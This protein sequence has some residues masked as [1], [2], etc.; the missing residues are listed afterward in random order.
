[1]VAILKALVPQIALKMTFAVIFHQLGVILFA[2]CVC[3]GHQDFTASKSLIKQGDVN[4]QG[5]FPIT[6]RE[7]ER[8][9]GLY[10]EGVIWAMAMKFAIDSINNSTRLQNVTLGYKIDNTCHHIPTSMHNAIEIVAKY[11]PNSVCYPQDLYCKD[12]SKG[13]EKISAV[14]GPALSWIAIPI[15]SLL[16][17]YEIPQI[18]YAS[19][20]RILS[21]KTRYNSFLRTVPS[22]EYQAKAMAEFVHKFGWN[23]VFLIASDD[24]YGKMGAAKF[25][26]TAKSLNVCIANDEYIPF[27]SDMLDDYVRNTLNT[28]KSSSRAKVVIVFTYAD[29]GERLLK[30]ASKM[31][32]TD[33]TWIA[34]D[35]WSSVTEFK[36]AKSLLEGIITFSIRSKK[37]DAFVDYINNLQIKDAKNIP[38]FLKY[39]EN[40]LN[41]VYGNVTQGAKRRCLPNETL[42]ANHTFSDEGIANVID[43][44][45]ATA[46]ALATILGCEK[47]KVCKNK[48]TDIKPLELLQIIKNSSFLG[49][50]NTKVEFNQNGDRASSGYTIRNVQIQNDKLVYVDV[51]HWSEVQRKT[52]FE[53]NASLIKWNKGIKPQ[54]N[55]FR[56]CQP[57]ER[58]VGQTECCWN[59]QRCEKGT[60]SSIQGALTCTKCNET[61]YTNSQRTICLARKVVYLSLHDPAGV[62]I[63][64]ISTL[65]IV[66]TSVIS[67]IFIRHRDTPIIATSTSFH[68]VMFF[69]ILYISFFFAMSFAL[70]KPS[71][72]MCIAIESIFELTMMLFSSFLLSKTRIVNKAARSALKQVKAMRQEW[73]HVT[74]VVVLMVLQLILV[75]ARQFVSP[76]HIHYVNQDKTRLLGCEQVFTSLRVLAI[77]VPSCILIIS[78]F[79][80]FRE[81]DIPDNFNEAKFISFTTILLCIIFISFI[82]TYKYVSGI[83]RILVLTFTTFVAAFSAMGCICIPKL[84]IIYMHPERNVN[85]QQSSIDSTASE[86][87]IPSARNSVSDGQSIDLN[88]NMKST[89][90]PDELN[91]LGVNTTYLTSFLNYGAEPGD[92]S[93]EHETVNQSKYPANH[94]KRKDSTD[95]AK[96]Q[97]QK[98]SRKK[99]TGRKSEPTNQNPEGKEVTNEVQEKQPTNGRKKSRNHVT[100]ELSTLPEMVEDSKNPDVEE[101][102]TNLGCAG[103][104]LET[105]YNTLDI[106]GT[107]R[108]FTVI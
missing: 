88:S 105:E 46:N 54:S 99:S 19:T 4:L 62:S 101:Q 64:I 25:K 75:I 20:S 91:F 5:L 37:V 48:N 52:F 108:A 89:A 26:N 78:T 24:D 79:I 21:D 85:S 40:V 83:S 16:G 10:N 87:P 15:A 56:L 33:R 74:V 93:I 9:Q 65:G 97:R 39:M 72:S 94:V 57:G 47:G 27:T 41:C 45:N 36:L 86:Q 61:H 34:S 96:G 28:L 50:D 67:G 43:A 30:E 106:R 49:V 11:R 14:I 81:R 35:G 77:T 12:G 69:F 95:N 6:Y 71:N 104:D 80:S 107:P 84:Y 38:W 53:V 55:C 66:I 29:Q 42:S 7:G 98:Y 70:H 92:E 44:V 58:I 51:G 1:M 76:S 63:L 82:S 18:S 68:L 17:L 3:F 2:I 13:V 22:D 103:D 8:C 90:R 23:Y 31:N 59:C 100:F 73:S 60:F 32:I 102:H